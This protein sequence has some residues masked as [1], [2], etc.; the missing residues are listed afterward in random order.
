[1]QLLNFAPGE[2]R[3]KYIDYLA[4][5][6]RFAQVATAVQ[7]EFEASPLLAHNWE[8]IYRDTLNAIVIGE[9]EGAD[10]SIVLPAITMHDLGFLFGA[11]GKTHAVVGADSVAIFLQKHAI[12]YAPD[13]MTQIANCIRTHKGSMH[14]QHPATLEAKVVTDADLLEKMGPV[15]LY[16]EFRTWT[17]FN[18]K[19]DDIIERKK[20]MN[21]LKFETKTGAAIASQGLE[22]VSNFVRELDT[23]LNPYR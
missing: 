10:M 12:T 2:L 6:E 18:L 11:T 20:H 15:G 19:A 17:E 23:A 4:G 22:Y 7:T 14:D 13:N 3:R 1:M 9:A 16:Q 5:D 21:Q 8:H